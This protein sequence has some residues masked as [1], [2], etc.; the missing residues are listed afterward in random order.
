MRRD[1]V[2]RSQ[3]LMPNRNV[4]LGDKLPMSKAVRVYIVQD[5]LDMCVLVL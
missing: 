4:V 2:G 1:A 3:F 5:L